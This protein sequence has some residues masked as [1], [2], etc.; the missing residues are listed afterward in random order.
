MNPVLLPDEEAPRVCCNCD[1]APPTDGSTHCFTCQR[2]KLVMA[3]AVLVW[4]GVLTPAEGARVAKRI[5]KE[6]TQ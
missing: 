3:R 5:R 4:H 2:D 1:A 6:F